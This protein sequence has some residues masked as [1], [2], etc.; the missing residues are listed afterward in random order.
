MIPIPNLVSLTLTNRCK[1]RKLIE[2][3][4]LYLQNRNIMPDLLYSFINW[5]ASKFQI[6][7][8]IDSMEHNSVSS[9]KLILQIPIPSYSFTEAVIATNSLCIFSE[10]FYVY[11]SSKIL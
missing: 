4:T 6:F 7:N 9:F 11:Y 10:I 8:N 2:T 1:I 3:L 5:K